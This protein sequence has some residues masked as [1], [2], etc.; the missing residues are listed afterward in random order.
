MKKAIRSLMFLGLAAVSIPVFA[1][2]SGTLRIEFLGPGGHSSNNY[3]RT[4]AVHAA[5][6][7]V[8]QIQQTL[9]T[10]SYVITDLTGGNSVNSIASDGLIDIRLTAADVAAYQALI[11]AV[12]AAANAGAAAENAFRGVGVGDLTSG[13]PAWIRTTFTPL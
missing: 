1:Q 9:P 11:T 4:N 12:T 10:G 8:I 13:V 2:Q 5:S 7:A 6:R 3:G